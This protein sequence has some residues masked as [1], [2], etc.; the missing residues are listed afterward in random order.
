[1]KPLIVVVGATGKQGGSVIKALIESAK[2]TVRGLSR[3]VSS[4]Q[5]QVKINKKQIYIFYFNFRN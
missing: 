2:W 3:N 5:S 4:K 1:M